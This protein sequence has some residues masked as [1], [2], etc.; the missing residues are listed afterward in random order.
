MRTF[1]EFGQMKKLLAHFPALVAQTKNPSKARPTCTNQ[2]TVHTVPT[3]TGMDDVGKLCPE[4][5][6]SMQSGVQRISKDH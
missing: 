3:C 2:F 6:P 4:S 5:Q 1:L